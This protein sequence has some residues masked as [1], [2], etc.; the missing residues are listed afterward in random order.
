MPLEKLAKVL[1]PTVVGT[2]S[3]L[4]HLMHSPRVGIAAGTNTNVGNNG[5][6]NKQ[7]EILLA[8]LRLNHVSSFYKR[9]LMLGMSPISYSQEYWTD[10]YNTST[11]QQQ[12][13]GSG[14]PKRG[15][16]IHGTINY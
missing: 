2:A 6:A 5:E 12:P 14:T 9:R 1:G 8:L 13:Y 15:H 7:V 3:K 11:L 16:A 4:S 10:F